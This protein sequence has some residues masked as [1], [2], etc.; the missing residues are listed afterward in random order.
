MEDNLMAH[1]WTQR[2]K[3]LSTILLICGSAPWASKKTFYLF[4]LI[5]V[6]IFCTVY[7]MQGPI[8][9]TKNCFLTK[10]I[11][12]FTMIICFA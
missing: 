4:F 6:I 10:N 9:L 7:A 3:T 1:C 11:S 8:I 5:F 2:K 12:F